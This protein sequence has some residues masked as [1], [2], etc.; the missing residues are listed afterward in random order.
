MSEHRR[1]TSSTGFESFESGSPRRRR[2]LREEQLI[3]QVAEKL[4]ETLERENVSRTELGRRLGKSKGFVSQILAGDKNLTLRTVADVCD[5]LGF[6]PHFE[7]MRDFA[8]LRQQIMPPLRLSPEFPRLNVSLMKPLPEGE[9]K[10]GA[11]A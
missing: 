10:Q 6:R 4:V 3:V 8:V 7:T 2:L 5:A 1:R 11:A 9:A